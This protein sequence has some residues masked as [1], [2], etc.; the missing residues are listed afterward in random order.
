M[1]FQRAGAVATPEQHPALPPGLND[2]LSGR[3]LHPVGPD[4]D[5]RPGLDFTGHDLEIHLYAQKSM[6]YATILP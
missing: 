4:H 2:A 3:E 1:R 6:E 5:G